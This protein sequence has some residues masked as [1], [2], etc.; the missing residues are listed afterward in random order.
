VSQVDKTGLCQNAPVLARIVK[1]IGK[2]I[3]SC[4]GIYPM[5]ADYSG[6]NG[7]QYRPIGQNEIKTGPDA[8]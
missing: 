1:K 8:M 3:P 2:S 6:H 7:H 5:M 4:A